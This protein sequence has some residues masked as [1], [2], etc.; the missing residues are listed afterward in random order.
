M[1]RTVVAVR[2]LATELHPGNKVDPHAATSARIRDT[3]GSSAP[4]ESVV[5]A[6]RLATIPNPALRL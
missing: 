4:S 1:V 5:S 6:L 2:M 3:S